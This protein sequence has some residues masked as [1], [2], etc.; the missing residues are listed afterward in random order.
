LYTGSFTVRKLTEQS[1][2]NLVNG[3]YVP[4]SLNLKQQ[5]D[6]IIKQDSDKLPVPTNETD[7]PKISRRKIFLRDF[8]PP[9]IELSRGIRPW[10]KRMPGDYKD[11]VRKENLSIVFGS[12]LFIYFVNLSPSITFA[13]LLSKF[14][15]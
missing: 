9:F 5:A 6:N 14:D 7:T 1:Q 13:A 12:V 3:S 8:C 4:S 2:N 11:A 15:Y 10:I